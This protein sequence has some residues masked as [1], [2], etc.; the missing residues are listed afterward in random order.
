MEKFPELKVI[1]AHMGGFLMWEEVLEKLA[2]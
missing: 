2:E 1:G